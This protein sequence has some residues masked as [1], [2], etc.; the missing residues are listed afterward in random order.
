MSHSDSIKRVVEILA[1]LNAGKE[2]C[3][4]RLATVYGVHIRT[5][6]RDL[7]LIREIFGA[8][9]TREGDCYRAYER[10]LLHQVLSADELMQLSTIVNV[11]HMGQTTVSLPEQT[12]SLIT[13]SNEVYEFRNKPLEYI[14]NREVLHCLE[15]AVRFRQV[16]NITYLTNARDLQFEFEVYRIVFVN[17]NFYAVGRRRT[18]RHVEFLRVSFISHARVTGDGFLHDSELDAFIKQIQTPLAEFTHPT[19]RV[20]LRVHRKVKKYFLAKRY[21]PSQS[22]VGEYE[23]GD[24]KVEYTITRNHEVENLLLQ[25][26]PNVTIVSPRILRNHMRKALEQKLEAVAK[27]RV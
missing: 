9:V 10:F 26:L 24:I 1:L 17:E 15:R 25:W 7:A 5:I 14:V 22:V 12:R 19:Q 23:N 18:N 16:L 3:V 4:G 6:R 27:N 20:V 13:H 11:L 8:V 21:L 2:V